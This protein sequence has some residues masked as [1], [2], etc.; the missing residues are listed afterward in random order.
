[1]GL[2]SIAVYS[3]SVGAAGTA[4]VG[5]QNGPAFFRG[6]RFHRDRRLAALDDSRIY[7]LYGDRQGAVWFAPLDVGLCRL[8]ADDFACD[9]S[10]E[11]LQGTTERSRPEGCEGS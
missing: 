1:A 10:L 8:A 5:T 3:L 6:G 9:N 11:A 7:T 2:P 4:W